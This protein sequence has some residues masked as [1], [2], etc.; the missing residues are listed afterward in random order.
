VAF[1][2]LLLVVFSNAPACTQQ[3][4]P[5]PSHRTQATDHASNSTQSQVIVFR[6]R[7]KFVFATLHNDFCCCRALQGQQTDLSLLQGVDLND[8]VELQRLLVR[9]LDQKKSE[10]N[11]NRWWRAVLGRVDPGQNAL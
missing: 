9:K 4:Q 7:R 3:C 5:F 2:L 10:K 11:L 8:P 6:F 1:L